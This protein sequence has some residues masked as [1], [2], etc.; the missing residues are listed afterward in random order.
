MRV[1]NYLMIKLCCCLIA[2]ILVGYY[3]TITTT[4]S[5]ILTLTSF[6][7]TIIAIKVFN[8]K[9]EQP[10]STGF[11]SY[12]S[13]FFIGTLCLNI[14]THYKQLN[15]YSNTLKEGE[16]HEFVLQIYKQ[17]K[18]NQYHLKY[19]AKVKQVND[20]KV[21][22]I[23]LIQTDTSQQLNIDNL[24]FTKGLIKTIKKP[25]NP[26]QFDYNAYMKKQQVYHQLSLN[27]TNS[28]QLNNT[29][30]IYGYAAEIRSK[31]NATLKN[32]NLSKENLSIINALLLGQ[33]QDISKET[34]T[35]FTNSGAIH[36]L[37]IS[38]LHIGLL[39]LI[40]S[41]ILKPLQYFK[42][43]KQFIPLIIIVILWLYA[44][45]AG[46]SASVVRAV[47][48]FSL[49]TIAHYHKRITNT[50]NT[51]FISAFILLLFN[52]FYL[53]D[54]GFQLSYLAVFAIIWIK[55]LFDK[56]WSPKNVVLKKGWNIFTV[57]IAAQLGILPLS[58]YYFHQFPGL[59]FITNLV[60]IP[61]LGLL[62][63][64]GMVT[65]IFAYYGWI[66]NFLISILDMAIQFLTDFVRYI[67]SKEAFLF[68]NISF[69]H[70]NL[71]TTYFLIIT[72]ILLWK[73]FSF[74]NFSLLLI[75]ILSIQLVNLSNKSEYQKEE[76]IVFNQYKSTLIANRKNDML[77]YTSNNNQYG[78]KKLL[79]YSTNE[80][81]NKISQDSLKN[82]FMIN[83]KLILLLD[84]KGI[85]DITFKPDIIVLTDSP[86]VNLNRVIQQLQ[87][88]QIIIDNNNYKSYIKRWKA[89]CIQQKIPFHI[90]CE[91]GAAVIR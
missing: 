80:F 10:I 46:F 63:T 44:F 32:H 34:Y 67:S 61:L 69:N 89:T 17:L 4:T 33:R 82:V 25:L 12:I 68:T 16:H 1:L 58:L 3:F 48:M 76:F 28:I 70:L 50:Y 72:T 19:L 91:K 51:L 20:K 35:E 14:H 75:A 59:F 55:P 64:I 40:L 24:L 23:I 38:G 71:I 66:P 86:R 74:R 41:W 79:D 15:H 60:I 8:W 56:L 9:I 7:A 53:F 88:K 27:A 65:L 29:T 36:I 5:I 42:S 84:K 52:P 22:G 77:T 83:Q 2:G 18:P 6:S 62:L 87:P 45:L 85:Y 11:L 78:Y 54:I 90:T 39:M 57:T 26:H 47:T 73:K 49:F 37:A 30:S 43:G 13:F 21:S 81:I 31:I